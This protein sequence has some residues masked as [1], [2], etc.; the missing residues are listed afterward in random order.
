MQRL[1]WF[2]IL[3]LLW[4]APELLRQEAK[5]GTAEGDVYSWA[6]VCSEIVTGQR[7]YTEHENEGLALEGTV[8]YYF[9]ENDS[10]MEE[11]KAIFLW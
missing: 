3:E 6:I 5:I 9:S 2:C 4:T 7:A 11:N 8:P 10:N 1:F